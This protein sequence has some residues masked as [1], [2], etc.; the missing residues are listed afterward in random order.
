[1]HKIGSL[2]C[3]LLF[4]QSLNGQTP[5]TRA[6]RAA[7]AAAP[8]AA[9]QNR[10]TPSPPTAG[11]RVRDYL[12]SWISPVALVSAGA[13]AGLGQWRDRPKEWKE[14]SEAFGKRYGSAYAQHMV[15]S[16]LMLG[17]SSL[18]GEDNRYFPSGRTGFG[19]RV[20]YA[21]ESSFLARRYDSSGQ[22][23]RSLSISK[24]ISLA[25]AAAVSRLWQPHSTRTVRSGLLSFGIEFG[26]GTG[27][28]V[29]REY[30]PGIPR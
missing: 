8:P 19:P 2:G 28:N 5:D 20:G 16:T 14:G 9:T 25:G 21:I 6:D 4:A 26:V 3:L 15:A 7:A 18:F 30:I 23:H 12:K 1:M 27:F 11:D 24:I 29:G 17:T 22:A 13:S 10:L